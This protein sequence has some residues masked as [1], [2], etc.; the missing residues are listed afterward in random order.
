MMLL[1]TSAIISILR[2]D[3]GVKSIIARA[4]KWRREQ[5]KYELI[6]VE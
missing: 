4:L 5:G 1:D 6:G 2:G 3:S